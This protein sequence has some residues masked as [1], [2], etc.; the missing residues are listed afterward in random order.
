M[1]HIRKRTAVKVSFAL[2]ALFVFS[3]C[4][5]PVNLNFESA[6]M[7]EKGDFELQG[8]GSSYSLPSEQ[9]EIDQLNIGLKY[10]MGI[11]DKY[12]LKLR[13]EGLFPIWEGETTE[14]FIF[15]EIDNKLK[16]GKMAA[17]SLPLGVYTSFSGGASLQF[18]PRFY[19]TFIQTDNFDLTF[20]P[21]C[22]IFGLR[23]DALFPG[24]SIGAGFSSDFNKWAIRPEVGYDRLS[25]SGG[26]SFTYF[27]KKSN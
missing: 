6:K 4:M 5:V 23:K 14:G 19:L 8:N 22:H 17:V 15:I 16:L 11:T 13:V 26:I 24:I 25:L 9:M 20:I 7:L 2:L 21:K 12:N 27:F 3:S 18:D 10:G 1:K